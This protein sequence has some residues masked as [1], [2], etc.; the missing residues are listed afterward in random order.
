M[1]GRRS[2][3]PVHLTACFQNWA[4]NSLVLKRVVWEEKKTWNRHAS[5]IAPTHFPTASGRPVCGLELSGFTRKAIIVWTENTAQHKFH[6]AQNTIYLRNKCNA[7]EPQSCATK[8]QVEL[9]ATLTCGGVLEQDT[10]S[11]TAPRSH[12]RSLLLQCGV[13]VKRD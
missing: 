4:A 7:D 10:Y 3:S 8:L 9:P 12:T 6:H 11:P 5:I 2:L 1:A 13:T